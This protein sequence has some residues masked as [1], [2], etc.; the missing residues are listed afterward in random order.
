LGF[1]K[2]IAEK[3]SDTQHKLYEAKEQTQHKLC[4][5]QQNVLEALALD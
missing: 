5:A 2:K 1:N 4:E 3:T